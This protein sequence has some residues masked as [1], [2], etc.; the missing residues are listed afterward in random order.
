[1]WSRRTFLG[2]MG[3]GLLGSSWAASA[4]P[5]A[6]K[7][8]RLAIVTTEWRYRSH[9][10]HMGERFLVGYPKQGR[11]H[12]PPLDVVAAYVDQHPEGDLSV[13]RSEE[14]GFPIFKSIAEAVRELKNNP[15]LRE[16]IR[17]Q[18]YRKMIQELSPE[19]IGQRFIPA[20]RTIIQTYGKV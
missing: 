13:K 12:R 1:M 10:W 14:F 6:D 3:A 7:R 15:G 17:D 20:L 18:A 11:W 19:P 4:E 16:H 8:K 2:A 9:A 5:T